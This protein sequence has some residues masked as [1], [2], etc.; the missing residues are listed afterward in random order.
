MKNELLDKTTEAM[1]TVAREL[2]MEIARLYSDPES[3]LIATALSAN[4]L[5][6]RSELNERMLAAIEDA[7]VKIGELS[8]NYQRD[9]EA[10]WFARIGAALTACQQTPHD[11]VPSGL[12]EVAF[13]PLMPVCEL[14]G[15]ECE[16]SLTPHDM[17]PS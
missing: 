6:M 16:Y 13:A 3:G 8:E 10:E 7:R 1:R 12:D 14:T 17:I 4:T 2:N 9:W 11:M 5:S 15:G